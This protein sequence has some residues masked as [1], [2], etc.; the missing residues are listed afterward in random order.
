[1]NLPIKL[2]TLLLVSFVLFSCQEAFPDHFP[3][4]GM[5]VEP[6]TLNTMIRLN[7]PKEINTFHL[8][9][10][11]LL[12]LE[13][14]SNE[15]WLF[16]ITE[17]QIFRFEN[18][19][20]QKISNGIISIGDGDQVEILEPKGTWPEG[21][22]LIPVAP[23]VTSDKPVSL[24]VFILVHNKNQENSEQKIAGAFADIFLSP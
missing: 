17:I 3:D 4:L 23:V 22:S 24:R 16:S 10:K 5:D 20:W 12:E 8:G 11:I 18:N 7:V 13:N 6:S 14:L 21:R 9:G 2:I 15:T 1:M 19:S